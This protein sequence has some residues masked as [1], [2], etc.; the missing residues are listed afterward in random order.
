[1]RQWLTCGIAMLALGFCCTA[2]PVARA[3]DARDD[4]PL[5][6]ASPDWRDQVIYFAVTDRFDDGDPGN[7]DQ[8]AGEFDPAD[9]RR[10]SGGDFA[11][12]RRRLDYIRG[13]GATAVWLT[14]PVAHQWISPRTGYGGYHGYWATDF[15]TTDPHYG[16][17]EEYRALSKALHGR[18]MYLVQDVVVNHVADYID[19]ADGAWRADDPAAGF[20]RNRDVQGQV[21]PVQPPFDRNDAASAADR[22]AAIYHWTPDIADFADRTQELDWQL[23]GL[24]DLDTATPAVRRALR[25]SHGA[26]IADAG[27][28][29]FRIDTAFHVPAEYLDDFVHG[30]GDG[31]PGILEAAGATGRNGFLVFGEGF[32]IDRAFEDVQARKLEAYMHEDGNVRVPG[33]INFPLYGSLDA[34]FAR[35]APTAELGHRIRSMVALHPRLH[36]MPS[37]VDNHDVD[38]FL[39]GGDERALRQALLALMTLPGIPTLYYGTEQGFTARRASMFAGGV[40]SGGGDHF[41]TTAPLYRFIADAT[42]LR[43]GHPLFSRGTPEV[44]R[45]SAGAPGAI[46]WRTVHD[47]EAGLVVFNTAPHAVLADAIATG[48]AAGARLEGVFGLD[49]T[50]AAVTA[51]NGGRLDLVLPPRSAQVWRWRDAVSASAGVDSG[52]H[53][54]VAAPAE[55]SSAPAATAIVSIDPLPDAAVTGDL[56]ISGQAPAQATVEVVADGDLSRA[57]TARADADGRWS[58]RLRTDAMLDP[59]RRHRVVARLAPR[60]ESPAVVSDAREFA[61]A[62]TWTPRDAVDDPAGDDHG[63]AGTYTYPTGEGWR[64][65]HPGDIRA[66]RVST[67]G[68]ALRVALEMASVGDDWNPPNGFDHVAI[69]LYVSLPG[70]DGARAMPGQHAE[71]PGDLRWQVRLRA[72]GWSNALTSADGADAEN[73]GRALLPGA[74][75][76]VDR[77]ARTLVFTLPATAFG[78]AAALQG[79]TV[80][81]TTWDYDGGF[82]P[83]APEATRGGFGGGAPGDPRVLDSATATIPD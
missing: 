5:H 59:A 49:G 28:D 81:A 61:V 25:A 48:A 35:G 23:A 56:E 2:A 74:R 72:H 30:A 24:D 22:A 14:P 68:G 63:P 33:M 1:M 83:L 65:Q 11:G 55:T 31:T 45:D 19:Y 82:R 75:I 73:D 71:L 39:A 6:V 42:A 50:P 15:R 44:L 34:V 76:D 78:D 17:P 4:G 38:R 46:A 26:W 16:S 58:A 47:G 8:G 21:A 67:S 18:G 60:G 7:N 3:A 77:A 52:A 64:T 10:Y 29:A 57:I 51:G 9:R 43:R 37:F 12:V 20:T 66:M 53:A 70:R 27:V 41:D 36:W 40:D 80:H 62:R 69:A 54:G 79:A 13:L 32:G